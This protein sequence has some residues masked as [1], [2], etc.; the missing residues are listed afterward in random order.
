MGIWNWPPGNFERWNARRLNFSRAER[1]VHSHE[2]HEFWDV[3]KGELP[4]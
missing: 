3:H 1:A 4:W 2:F